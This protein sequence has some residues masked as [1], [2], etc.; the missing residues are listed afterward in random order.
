MTDNSDE[1]KKLYEKISHLET[2]VKGLQE[3]V[4][5]LGVNIGGKLATIEAAIKS[6]KA[7]A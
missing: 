5:I 6:L 7:A 4:G 3:H 2:A 1:I